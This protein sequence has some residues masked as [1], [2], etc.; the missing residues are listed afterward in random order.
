MKPHHCITASPHHNNSEIDTAITAAIL[1]GRKILEIYDDPNT[2]FSVER[3]SD[4]SPLTIADK[5][6]HSI[7]MQH[8]ECTGIPVLS[9][10]GKDIPYAI[11]K[12]WSAFWL[13]DPLDGTKEFI[14]RNGEFTVNIALIENSMPSAGV[15]YIPVSNSLYVGMKGKDAYKISGFDSHLSFD[16]LRKKGDKLPI[17]DLP[18]TYTIVGSRSHMSS[19]TEAYITNRKEVF[20]DLETISIGSSQKICL[21]A[22]GA[23][24]EYPRFG[25]TMEWDT[26]AGH[27][28]ANAAGRKLWLT[29]LSGEL[30]Y[31]KE[32]LLNPYFIVK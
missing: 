4:N 14:K 30:R 15:I 11:R 31:N 12:E 27:A 26:A 21:V 22:E 16:D 19:G 20:P 13:V 18:S 10:E 25:P 23:A 5:A 8:L 32:S 7:I 17:R 3:K 2:D 9:E 24:H 6:S 28:I 29:D 1:A